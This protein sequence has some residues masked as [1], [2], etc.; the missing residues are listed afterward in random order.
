MDRDYEHHEAAG[1][2]TDTEKL[3]AKRNEDLT[4]ELEKTGK[5]L[6]ELKKH[7]ER[8]LHSSKSWHEKYEELLDKGQSITMLITP[9]KYRDL[10]CCDFP[11]D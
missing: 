11:V 4:S 3:L 8:L 6:K 7:N 5:Q 2:E 9:K 1:L 10:S